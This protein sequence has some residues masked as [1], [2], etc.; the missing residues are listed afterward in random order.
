MNEQHYVINPSKVIQIT[1][2]PKHHFCAQC[3][4]DMGAE[5]ILGPV[6]GKCCRKNHKKVTGR[7]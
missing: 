3:H 7:K 2:V 6:C 1:G 4:R 5:W